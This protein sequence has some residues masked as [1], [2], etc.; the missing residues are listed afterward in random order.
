VQRSATTLAG[1]ATSRA[2][3]KDDSDADRLHVRF[4]RRSIR[5]SPRPIA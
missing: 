2:I 4:W 3:L 1:E 5:P